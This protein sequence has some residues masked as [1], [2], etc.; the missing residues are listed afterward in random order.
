MASKPK[1]PRRR[2]SVAFKKRVAAEAMRAGASTAQI[3]RRYD[4]TTNLV[5]NWKKKFGSDAA[6]MPVEVV[7]DGSDLLPSPR[8]SPPCVEIDLPCGAKIR[9]GAVVN[10]AQLAAIIV[11][12]RSKR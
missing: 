8:Q 11:A 5:L 1:P 6:L 2:W 10:S 9:F 3:A 4:L 12:L 7:A